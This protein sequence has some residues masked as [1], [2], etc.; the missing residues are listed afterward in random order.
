M[1]QEQGRVAR[2]VTQR[3]KTVIILA[4]H[5]GDGRWQLRIQGRYRQYFTD[6][7]QSFDSV[8]QAVGAAQQAIRREGI[9]SFY[10]PRSC[11]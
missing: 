7:I 11:D 4:S 10:E 2:T 6:W 8:A 5:I 3:D 9:D 1:V